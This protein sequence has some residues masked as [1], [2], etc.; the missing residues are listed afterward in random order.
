MDA[1][2]AVAYA[3]DAIQRALAALDEAR[4]IAASSVAADT[5]HGPRHPRS[6]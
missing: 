6:P 5:T 2:D 3:H 1:D 4:P